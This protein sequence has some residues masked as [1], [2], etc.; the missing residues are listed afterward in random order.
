M[1][2]KV[3]PGSAQF[4]WKQLGGA[5]EQELWGQMVWVLS[6]PAPLSSLMTLVTL[7]VYV[8]FSSFVNL[9][10]KIY[11]PGVNQKIMQEAADKKSL[12][13]VLR[14]TVGETQIWVT[15]KECSWEEKESGAYKDKKPRGC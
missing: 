9:S 14:I 1:T 8:L 3:P 7:F 13:G 2:F 5:A 4:T 12:F 11:L 6:P 10:S 15:L